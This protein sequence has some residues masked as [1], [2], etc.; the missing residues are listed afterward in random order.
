MEK[1]EKNGKGIL[2]GALVAIIIILLGLCIY[3][4]FVKK[5]NGVVDDN[6]GNQNNVVNDLN[7]EDKNIVNTFTSQYPEEGIAT[8]TGYATV[9]KRSVCDAPFCTDENEPEQQIDYVFFNITDTK[10]SEF[11]KFIEKSKGNSFVG[12]NSIGLGC[13]EKGVITY[14]NNSD[15]TGYKSYTLNNSLSSDILNSSKDKAITLEL[16]KLK[17]SFGGYADICYSHITNVK[18]IK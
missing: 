7:E 17:L 2:I 8:V 12:D 1:K 11:L 6:N 4:L 14:N 15:K 5:D 16:E 10:S 9:V 13:L 18:E 3:L